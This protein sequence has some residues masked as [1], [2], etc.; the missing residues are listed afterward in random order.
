MSRKKGFSAL[1]QS[2][3]AVETMR[4]EVQC[5]F[6]DPLTGQAQNHYD[7]SPLSIIGLN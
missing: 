7:Q 5:S 4:V 1:G 3:V 2:V 6:L